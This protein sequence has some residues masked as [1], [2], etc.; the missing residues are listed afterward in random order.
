[1]PAAPSPAPATVAGRALAARIAVWYLPAAGEKSSY[2]SRA[3]AILRRAALFRPG[4]IG[5][6]LYV[7]LL[8]VVLPGLALASVRCLALAAGGSLRR[9]A[10][11]VYAI[12][13]VNFA[14]WAL[15]TPPFQAPD[16]VDHF[17]YTQSF[18][19]RGEAP[20]RDAGSPR[21]RWSSSE[22]LLL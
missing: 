13:A 12:A 16:E 1:L 21:L 10:A 11:G 19:E 2:L 15:M 18:V 6:W 5:P 3:R 20:S 9:S 14:C 8:L 22:N 17:A 7:A 4:F